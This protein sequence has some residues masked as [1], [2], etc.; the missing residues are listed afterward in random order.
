MAQKYSQMSQFGEPINVELKM[1]SK[2]KKNLTKACLQKDWKA[3][4]SMINKNVYV[5]SLTL[6]KGLTPLH[7]VAL[8]GDVPAMN[9]MLNYPTCNQGILRDMLSGK[10]HLSNE[11]KAI[12][13][14]KIQKMKLENLSM[15][16][17][18][19]VPECSE[20]LYQYISQV[21]RVNMEIGL[22]IFEPEKCSHFHEVCGVVFHSVSSDTLS[23]VKTAL[24]QEFRMQGIALSGARTV[25]EFYNR[26]LQIYI[27]NGIS[28]LAVKEL[29]N[30]TPGHSG[31]YFT[32]LNAI[33]LYS[34]GLKRCTST[35]YRGVRIAQ[36]E[37]DA[38]SVNKEFNWL[39]LVSCSTATVSDEFDGNCV[40]QIDN[41]VKCHWSPRYLGNDDYVYPCGAQ[42]R[43]IKV[44]KIG[45]KMWIYLKLMPPSYVGKFHENLKTE[46]DKIVANIKA[47]HSQIRTYQES[48]AE[49]CRK[50]FD[51][52]KA[53]Q[54]KKQTRKIKKKE[55]L[56]KNNRF[57]Y[58]CTVCQETC[59][60]PC[61]DF[62]GGSCPSVINE[63][64]GSCSVCPGKCHFTQ[65]SKERF[66]IKITEVK[67]EV[68][69]NAA[70]ETKKVHQAE[71]ELKSNL[72]EMDQLRI[73]FYKLARYFDTVLN[74]KGEEER[75]ENKELIRTI[76][77]TKVM[78]MD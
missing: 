1:T 75:E 13:E 22:R 34:T 15:P 11:I 12:I 6:D 47:K 44:E 38:Y 67:N 71:R 68:E 18:K 46:L 8:S 45:V 19:E 16:I 27:E 69:K 35:T 58:N 53:Q 39:L 73:D 23:T 55:V 42:F 59:H 70:I 41:S 4:F 37:I 31:I 62:R 72:A 43:V 33:L 60:K 5:L 21:V 63:D 56:L 77:E 9:Q 25:A 7:H 66:K 17:F 36:R 74:V 29:Y 65:H 28:K 40:F 78:F 26:I 51:L 52:R 2:E 49:E 3:V 14:W 24:N 57:A 61:S 48:Y 64:V 30:Q 54:N 32:L 76:E 10:F 20:I 50:V